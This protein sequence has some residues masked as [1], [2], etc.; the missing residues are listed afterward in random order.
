MKGFVGAFQLN[1]NGFSI[2]DLNFSGL[3]NKGAFFTNDCFALF[4]VDKQASVYTSISATI[5]YAGWVRLDNITEITTK[6]ALNPETPTDEIVIEAY[7]KWGKNCVTHFIGDF[8]FVI[9]DETAKKLFLAKDQIGIRPLFYIEYKGI[10]IFSTH[11]PLIKDILPEQP[12]ISELYV[13][14][15]LRNLIPPI[16]STFFSDIYRLEPAH[17]IIVS[18]D[19]HLEKE[20]YWTLT[21]IELPEF[22]DD[23]DYYELIRQT[24]KEAISWRAKHKQQIG[25]QLSGGLDSS[26][27]TVL[28]SRLLPKQQLHTYSF[29]LDDE[30]RP[31]SNN[32]LDER[33]TQEEIIRYAG[34]IP[35][36]HH[37]I[38]K[39]HYKDAFEELDTRNAVMGGVASN[40]SYWQDTL[41]KQAGESE[42]VEVMFSGF[43]GDEGISASAYNYFHE[44]LYTK[45]WRGI[46]TYLSKFRIKGLYRIFNYLRYSMI[47][48]TSPSFNAIQKERNLLQSGSSFSKV[49]PY[50]P[51]EFYT[52]FKEWLKNR[53]LATHIP[54][55]V[56]SELLYANQ[57]NIEMVYPLAD[58]RLLQLVYSLPV[59]LFAPIPLT[60]ALFRNTCRGILPENVRQQSKRNG[61]KTLAF[62]DYILAIR[63]KELENYQIKNTLN[64]LVS[65]KDYLK[66]KFS[67]TMV[68]I[69]RLNMIKEIDYLIEQNLKHK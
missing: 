49:Q 43:P 44:Y 64:L 45:D 34:L 35:E 57:Y 47:G 24:L 68:K 17:Y 41:F 36:N 21:P 15:E 60:R 12:V 6:L 1:N 9:F 40:D 7:L 53:M 23:E 30:T 37:F 59:R 31:Y 16:E 27:I 38:T 2:N 25:C 63:K 3:L 69:K 11:I 32:G 29:I 18:A 48:T 65:E 51:F 56:E 10:L 62:I 4:N 54:L 28:L 33:R 66:R 58:I 20:C 39:F 67:N 55:R 19:G 22:T 5:K 8:S 42:K 14:Y 26:A 46:F 13:S 52:S 50:I 61:A